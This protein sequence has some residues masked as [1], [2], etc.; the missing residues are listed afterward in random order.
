MQSKDKKK[1]SAVMILGILALIVAG[2]YS[3]SHSSSSSKTESTSAVIGKLQSNA[4]V[5]IGSEVFPVTLDPTANASAAIDEVVDYNVLQ[6]LVEL[7]P[8]GK[9][10]PVLATSWTVSNGN[11]VYTFNIRKGVKFSNGDPL[12]SKDVVYSMDRVFAPGSTYPYGKLFDVSSVVE[13]SPYQVKVTLTKPS[14]EWLFDLAA[15][16]NGVII[17]PRTVSTLGTDPI[18]TGPY[19]V[20]SEVNNYSITLSR[21][22]LYYGSPARAKQVIFHYFSNPNTEDA[23]LESGQIQVIDN[24]GTPSEVSVF[25]DSPKYRVITGPTNG[26]VQL[27]LNNSYGPL[28]NV[29]V[30]QAIAY[31][32][33][34][35]AIIDVASGGYGTPL[36]SDSVPA[37]PYYLD[38]SNTYPYNPAKARELLKQA[39]YPHGFPLTITLPPYPYA[40]LAGPLLA[41][42][43]GSVG[44]DVKLTNIQWPLWISQVFESG[45]FQA[46]VIDHAEA[47]DIGNYATPGYYWHY[48][49]TSEVAKMIGDANQ[50]PTQAQ[51]IAG[52]Q[53]VLHKI[54][55]AAVNDW[56][57]ILPQI[58]VTSSNVTGVPHSGY[59]ESFN[60]AYLGIGGST[61]TQAKAMGF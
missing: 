38:L 58:T 9:I 6:H 23:A 10:V 2:I 25:K 51:W 8:K 28:S 27:T 61:S 22:S 4:T 5:T 42:E 16:S 17:D 24:L 3:I 39:G 12:T 41:S 57:Y 43:L 40:Q 53:A 33:D 52:Y 59:S 35:K 37:D 26:K 20:T 18:G 49:G 13:T 29:M 15:Y 32:T 14:W 30:R 48:R 54:T 11:S 44:I 46:T 7:D 19:K 56:L 55:N 36:G 31:A 45:D 1:Q 21:N 34:K 60:L 47:R 50:A